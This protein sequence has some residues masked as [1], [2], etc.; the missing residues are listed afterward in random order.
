MSVISLIS[1]RLFIS[2]S[3]QP[4][5]IWPPVYALCSLIWDTSCSLNYLCINLPLMSGF[6]YLI[7]SFK[8]IP[9]S[10]MVCAPFFSYTL[11]VCHLWHSASVCFCVR[12]CELLDKHGRVV[13][14]LADPRRS[15]RGF[16]PCIQTPVVT[17]SRQSEGGKM[18][19]HYFFIFT[20]IK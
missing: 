16:S 6:L 1:S 13:L 20:D 2:P 3:L 18:S 19:C 11:P 5:V 15:E 10:R 7:Q 14:W 17:L 4:S 8:G 12:V 9:V